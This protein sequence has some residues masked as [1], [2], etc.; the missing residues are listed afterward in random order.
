MGLPQLAHAAHALG[1]IEIRAGT[2]Q[3]ATVYLELTL[4]R[5]PELLAHEIEHVLEQ[6]DGVNLRALASTGV[7]GVRRIGDAYETSR[8]I[9]IGRLVADEVLGYRAKTEGYQR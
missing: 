8:A 4:W 3:R 6:I 9:A 2:P 1:R 5:A 7:Q